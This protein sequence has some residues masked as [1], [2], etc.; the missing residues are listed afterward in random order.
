MWR[1]L[2]SRGQRPI[3]SNSSHSIP[4]QCVRMRADPHSRQRPVVQFAVGLPLQ[5]LQRA[6]LLVGVLRSAAQV[7]SHLTGRRRGSSTSESRCRLTCVFL[8]SAPLICRT[9]FIVLD[10]QLL[11]TQSWRSASFALFGGAQL[12][13]QVSQSFG[14]SVGRS[15]SHRSVCIR[16]APLRCPSVLPVCSDVSLVCLIAVRVPRR[17]VS[18]PGRQTLPPL[19]H[20]IVGLVCCCLQLLFSPFRTPQE[21]YAEVGALAMLVTLAMLMCGGKPAALTLFVLF[22]A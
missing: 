8:L 19:P 12:V 2:S 4:I 5:I 10:T 17:C 16:Y 21:N 14:Q 11:Q 3:G 1:V 9:V 13:L 6:M 22:A 20:P 18:S 15:R 7:R